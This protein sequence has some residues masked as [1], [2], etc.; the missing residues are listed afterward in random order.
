MK[1]QKTT[2]F[3]R[4]LLGAQNVKEVARHYSVDVPGGHTQLTFHTLFVRCVWCHISHLVVIL[5]RHTHVCKLWGW[6]GSLA[7]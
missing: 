1:I 2:R 4:L 5:F 3:A 6:L 7:Y